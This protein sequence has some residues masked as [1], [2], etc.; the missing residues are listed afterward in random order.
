MATQSLLYVDEMESP[1]GP[2]TIVSSNKGVCQINFGS[3]KDVHSILEQWAKKYFLAC[4]L[5]EHPEMLAPV[6]IELEEYFSGIRTHFTF[7]MDFQGTTFQKQ[8]WKALLQ[9]PYGET[10]SYKD[11]AKTIKSP[12]AVRA[13]G[14]AIN[15]NPIAIAVPC[16]RVIGSNGALV[17]Y[18]GGLDKKRFLLKHENITIE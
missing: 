10:R 12:K 8:V 7:P 1:I 6:K 5:D 16:H 9:I 2:L 15:R 4:E 13:V 11:I 17:G 3:K 14:G 18:N